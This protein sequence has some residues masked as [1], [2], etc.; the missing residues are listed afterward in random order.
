MLHRL[1]ALCARISASARFQALTFAAILANGLVL[2]MQTYEGF[3]RAH[4]H[5][6]DRLNTA[7]LTFF[8]VEIAIRVIAYGARPWRFFADGWNVFDFVMVAPALIPGVRENV[9]AL[10]VVRLLRVFRV[11]SALPEMRVLVQ[12]LARSTAPLASM[13]VLVLLLFYAYGMVGWIL[14]DDH[15]PEHWGSLGTA[16]LT[17]FSVLTLEG[18]V[19]IQET[20]LR[21]S[22]WAWVYFV[23]F[24][25]LSSF[26]LLNMVIAVLINGVEEARAR[27]AEE[28]R[29]LLHSAGELPLLERLGALRQGLDE[30]ERELVRR[31]GGERPPPG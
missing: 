11:V 16:M 7:F 26:V 20:A 22:E 29:S 13:A 8:V 15:D 28:R 23:S 10:R 4:G 12:G 2:G 24:V 17:L 6:L 25:L 14:F 1:V 30:L 21:L 18:W 3:E 19:D 27:A 9:T 31:A 5:V